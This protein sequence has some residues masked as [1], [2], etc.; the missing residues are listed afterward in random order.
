[1]FGH[2]VYYLWSTR[3]EEAEAHFPLFWLCDMVLL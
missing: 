2:S 1:M 3:Q